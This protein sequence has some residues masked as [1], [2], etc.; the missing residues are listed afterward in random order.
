MEARPGVG[1]EGTW[2]SGGGAGTKAGAQGGL[3][4]QQSPILFMEA[5]SRNRENKEVSRKLYPSCQI[6]IVL[7]IYENY[8]I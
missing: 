5:A 2:A 6:I 3:G 8:Y 7:H 4:G 1:G